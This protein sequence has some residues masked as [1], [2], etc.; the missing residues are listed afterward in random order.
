LPA[1]LARLRPSITRRPPALFAKQRQIDLIKN[2]TPK[3]A[4]DYTLRADG[5]KPMDIGSMHEE[6]QA[7]GGIFSL[8]GVAMHT[9]N[10]GSD[11]TNARGKVFNFEV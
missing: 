1:Q 5:E 4:I 6:I 8:T 11:A 7:N 2:N 9:S 10:L 3:A